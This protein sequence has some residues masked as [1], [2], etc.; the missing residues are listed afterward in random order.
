M[1]KKITN[2]QWLETAPYGFNRVYLSHNDHHKSYLRADELLEGPRLPEDFKD[3]SGEDIE[4]MVRHD[5]VWSLKVYPS[6]P[7]AFVCFHASTLDECLDKARAYFN[8][9]EWRAKTAGINASP[10]ANK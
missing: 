1:N 2:L 10:D 4:E 5:S 3:C 8:L 7:V 9:M 6:D